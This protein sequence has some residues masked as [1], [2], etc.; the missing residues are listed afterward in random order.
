VRPSS[1]TPSLAADPRGVLRQHRRPIAGPNPAAERIERLLAVQGLWLRDRVRCTARRYRLDADELC[2]ELMLS[3]LRR[4]ATVDE[5]N[6]GVRSW[7]GGRVDWTAHDMLR[8]RGRE[9]IVSPDD[10]AAIERD[11]SARRPVQ[12]SPALVTLDVRYLIELGLTP[13]EAQVV[14]FR[15]TGIDMP[16]KEFADLVHRSHA[17]VRK[18]FERG[19]RKIENLFDLTAEELLVVRAWRRHGTAA[20]TAPHVNRT[21][22]DVIRILEGAHKKI[23]RIFDETEGRP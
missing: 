6:P 3:M 20:A 8:R 13:N 7:L 22:E 16:L 18:E 15:C 23:D 1:G 9:D 5:G 10:L 11:M 4:S 12:E 21:G 14:A 2:Q 17:S 19:T